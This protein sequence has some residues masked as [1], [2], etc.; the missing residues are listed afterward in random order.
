MGPVRLRSASLECLEAAN[1]YLAESV[2]ALL[3][4]KPQPRLLPPRFDP[5]QHD[6]EET[7]PLGVRRED[8]LRVLW[9]RAPRAPKAPVGR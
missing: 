4:G 5:D 2:V 9:S 7:L 3:N 1:A 6:P 8:L